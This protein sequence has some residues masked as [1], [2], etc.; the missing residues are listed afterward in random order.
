[1]S[2]WVVKPEE[3]GNRLSSYLQSKLGSQYSARQ[4]KHALEQNA[5]LIN[6]RIER[7]ATTLVGR[8]DKISFSG[9]VSQ[10]KPKSNIPILFQ[11]EFILACY[12]PA[13]IASEDTDLAPMPDLELLHRL[14]KE[15]TGILLW[16]KKPSF[17]KSMMDL[18]K[19]RK[20]KKTYLAVVDAVPKANSG[21]IENCL[22]KIHKYQGQSLWGPVEDGLTAIT[23]WE[24]QQKWKEAALL[25]C[26][27]QTGRTH[28][29]RVHL[30][31]IGHPILGDKQYGKRF[32]CSYRPARCLL[33]AHRI[34][35]THPCTGNLI[36]II[37]PVPDDFTQACRILG[38]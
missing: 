8:G 17:T 9:F 21:H 4:I 16:S 5:C 15:T 30:S 33:H 6:G 22:G 7:H 25:A 24:L 13:G 26:Y 14:D 37:A 23:D 34:L 12:K 31:G 10:P 11:D 38:A 3:S 36:E 2:E 35:F 18:F 19:Y 28:Q 29:I 32:L 20:I 1:M 27:P